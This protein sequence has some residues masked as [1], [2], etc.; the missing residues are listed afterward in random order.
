MSFLKEFV[1]K[2]KE[3]LEYCLDFWKYADADFSPSIEAKKKWSEWNQV[4]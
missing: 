4:N 1:D 2:A 3:Y